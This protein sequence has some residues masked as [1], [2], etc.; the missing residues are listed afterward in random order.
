MNEFNSVSPHDYL[1]VCTILH[2]HFS[3]SFI[4]EGCYSLPFGSDVGGFLEADK[5]AYDLED[6]DT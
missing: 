1:G 2:Y 4:D 3:Q 6:E 5:S